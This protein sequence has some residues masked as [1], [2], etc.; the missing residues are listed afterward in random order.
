MVQ[1]GCWVVVLFGKKKFYM[2]IV[3]NVY[4]VVL[5][6]YEMKDIVEVLDLF[7]VLLLK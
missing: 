3:I 6:G 7:L 1:I 2:V 4:Y 5:E